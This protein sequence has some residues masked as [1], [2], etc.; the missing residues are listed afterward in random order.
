MSESNQSNEIND[1]FQ[2]FQDFQD[3]EEDRQVEYLINNIFE[4]GY[5]STINNSTTMFN[6]SAYFHY[7]YNTFREEEEYHLFFD[8]IVNNIVNSM[9]GMYTDPLDDILQQS[10]EQQSDGL[11]KTDYN[12]I[13]SSQEYTSLCDKI[14]KDNIECSICTDEYKNTDTISITNCN[15]IFHTD[16]IK[17]WGKYKQDCPLCKNNLV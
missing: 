6:T 12:L 4:Q 9:F 8:N 13:I 7:A 5:N 14:K 10:F 15:H 2:D 1:D 11:E 17:E 16:C 3:F